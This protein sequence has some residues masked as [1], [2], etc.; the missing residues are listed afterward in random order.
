MN[1][2]PTNS[3]D[4]MGAPIYLTSD[5]NTWPLL[6]G[7][8]NNKNG[9]TTVHVG[10]VV[11]EHPNG[12]VSLK[13]V[14][15]RSGV[16]ADRTKPVKTPDKVLVVNG[17]SLFGLGPGREEDIKMWVAEMEKQFGTNNE[18]VENS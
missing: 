9:I 1:Q 17:S 13:T 10:Y 6:Y 11:K 18:T 5:A 3:F 15:S 4:A 12:K 14:H 2:T 7:Y 8:S 16:H